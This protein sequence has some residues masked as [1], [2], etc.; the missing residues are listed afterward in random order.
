MSQEN[1]ERVKAMSFAGCGGDDSEKKGA[2]KT[3]ASRP[4]QHSSLPR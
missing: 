1:V 3:S 2:A 4:G